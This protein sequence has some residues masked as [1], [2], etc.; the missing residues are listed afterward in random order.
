MDAFR[1]SL[2]LCIGDPVTRKLDVDAVFPSGCLM[3]FFY[4]DSR[5]TSLDME[6]W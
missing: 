5:G 1:S 4:V 3:V 2:H 6:R